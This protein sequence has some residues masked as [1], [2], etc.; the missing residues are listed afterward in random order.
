MRED[1]LGDGLSVNLEDLGGGF[2]NFEE[3]LEWVLRE[4]L[5]EGGGHG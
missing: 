5:G 2:C 1:W 4:E 3:G